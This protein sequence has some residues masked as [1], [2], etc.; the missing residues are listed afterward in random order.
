MAAVGIRATSIVSRSRSQAPRAPAQR[1]A[2]ATTRRHATSRIG[3]G[4][5]PGPGTRGAATAESGSRPEWCT[6]RCTKPRTSTEARSRFEVSAYLR[7][8]ERA[9][10]RTRTAGLLVTGARSVVAERCGGFRVPH[11]QDCLE[12][13]TRL[14]HLGLK[15]LLPLRRAPAAAPFLGPARWSSPPRRPA[16]RASGGREPGPGRW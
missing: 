15:V 2:T 4:R 1:R 12:I 13:T 5:V 8:I 6:G 16:R 14:V 11:G 7:R 10:E 3:T 9:D